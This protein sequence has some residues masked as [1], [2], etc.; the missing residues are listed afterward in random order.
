MYPQKSV[1]ATKWTRNLIVVACAV[2][3]SALPAS[4]SA[5][6]DPAARPPIALAS[7][8]TSEVTKLMASDAGEG[9][10]F[11]ISVARSGDTLIVGA[12]WDSHPGL[13]HSGSAYIFQRDPEGDTWS[14]VAKLVAAD[15]AT[16]DHFGWAVAISGDFVVVGARFSNPSGMNRAGSAYIFGRDHNGDDAW[17]QVAKLTASDATI[18]DEFGASVAISG[19]T[20]VVGATLEN[21]GGA[22]Y[23]FERNQPE[24]DTWGQATKLAADDTVWGDEF[25]TSAAIDEDTIVVG[26]PFDKHP[27]FR[28]T[29]SAYIFMRD[30]DGD[31]AW[32]Q[33]LK[34]TAADIS[35]GDAFGV[36]AAIDDDTVVVGATGYAGES[37]YVF[38]RDWD[39]VDAWGQVAKLTASDAASN[40]DFGYS[41]AIDDDTVVVGALY[42]GLSGMA[43]E[44]SAYIF[45]RNEGGTN[46]WGEAAKLTAS[47][48]ADEDR[49]GISVAVGNNLVF[50]G[51]NGDDH[52]G[53][54][55]AGSV[56][57]F[58]ITTD[59]IFSDGFESGDTTGWIP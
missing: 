5:S 27:G 49:F 6:D 55:S 22:A 12:V 41:L 57:L 29:G 18:G 58:Q 44:G 46:A 11:G 8:E 52:S 40:D 16:N 24:T 14:E 54:T 43:N 25:G 4:I 35:A 3:G 50:V 30:E 31:E 23:I 48:A 2:F 39:G 34:L 38:D 17:G 47:D 36:S 9:D 45:T 7:I 20:V 59:S 51:A 53:L 26:A 42:D 56:Y 10:L 19:D 15:A 1:S 33:L 28:E 13:Y 37:A 21:H 32:G